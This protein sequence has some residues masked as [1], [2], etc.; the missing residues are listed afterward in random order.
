[1]R[2]RHHPRLLSDL[3]DITADKCREIIALCDA[4]LIADLTDGELVVSYSV[5][6]AQTTLRG[7]DEILRVRNQYRA[8]LARTVSVRRTRVRYES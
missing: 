4:A 1:M 6:G 2:A 7:Y 3:G 8:L 5:G